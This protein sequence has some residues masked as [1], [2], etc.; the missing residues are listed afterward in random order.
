MRDLRRQSHQEKE[1]HGDH[2]QRAGCHERGGK[3]PGPQEPTTQEGPQHRSGLRRRGVRSIAGAPRLSRKASPNRQGDRG[4]HRR[5]HPMNEAQRDQPRYIS[6]E[7][8]AERRERKS[9]QADQQEPAAIIQIRERPC[10]PFEKAPRQRG[11]RD[12]EA[13]GLRAGAQRLGE[14]REHGHADEVVA[15]EGEESDAAQQRKL[16]LHITPT[17]P[18]ARQDMP[19]PVSLPSM[20]MSGPTRVT[21]VT[22]SGNAPL[23][24]LGDSPPTALSASRPP[25]I[26]GARKNSTRSTTLSRKA[27][28]FTSA[29]PSINSDAI[30]SRPNSFSK[31]R[32]AT[33]LCRAGSTSLGPAT[34]CHPRAAAPSTGTSAGRF[35]LTRGCGSMARSSPPPQPLLLPFSWARRNAANPRPRT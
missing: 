9:Q 2:A 21:D 35:V 17:R 19:F 16:L 7:Q 28:A 14:Q 23:R 11:G 5:R 8:V 24:F 10:R 12:D 27:E 22:F 34:S 3:S 32:H 30:P 26:L 20:R 1:Q 31:S 4:E 13:A 25:R 18:Q 29:P 33:R 15:D 6:D